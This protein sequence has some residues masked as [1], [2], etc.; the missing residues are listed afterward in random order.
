[1]EVRLRSFFILDRIWLNG[2]YFKVLGHCPDID[3]IDQHGETGLALTRSRADDGHIPQGI[4]RDGEGIGG[5]H[6]SCQRMT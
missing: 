5:T 4:G 3:Q 2:G 1:M 6:N